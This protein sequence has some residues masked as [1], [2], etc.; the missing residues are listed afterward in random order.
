MQVWQLSDTD[1]WL[2]MCT[3]RLGLGYVKAVAV[4]L[5]SG[6]SVLCNAT[7]LVSPASLP[8]FIRVA[9]SG[10]EGR[11]ARLIVLAR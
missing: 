3:V 7:A 1:V 5:P 10:K 9:L 11:S 2:C 4:Y 6:H 8:G